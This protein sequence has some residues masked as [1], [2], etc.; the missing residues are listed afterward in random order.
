MAL[1]PAVAP[2]HAC[3]NNPPEK[4]FVSHKLWL[5][6]AFFIFVYI[7]NESRP[8]SLPKERRCKRDVFEV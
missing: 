7:H 3:Q 8:F 2:I 1:K 5:A 4:A 6:N